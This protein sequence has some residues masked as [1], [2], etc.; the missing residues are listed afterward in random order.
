MQG[1]P[2]GGLSGHGCSYREMFHN[3]F[4]DAFLSVSS[5][6]CTPEGIYCLDITCIGKFTLLVVEQVGNI[7]QSF[8]IWF[9]QSESKYVTNNSSGPKNHERHV[10]LFLSSFLSPSSP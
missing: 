3:E 2:V 6:I 1:Y 7:K 8:G 5:S 9:C 4:T 10:A